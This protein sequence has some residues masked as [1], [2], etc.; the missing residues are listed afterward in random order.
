MPAPDQSPQP[1]ILKSIAFTFSLSMTDFFC[2]LN[3][4]TTSS[5]ANASLK[6]SLS[7]DLASNLISS[8][9]GCILTT[10]GACSSPSL[11]LRTS[12]TS[13][14]PSP[15]TSSSSSLSLSFSDTTISSFC[16]KAFG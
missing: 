4:S 6:L 2:A 13:A 9:S 15:F 3:S 10:C 7:R 14:S 1:G 16:L 12:V 8:I 5:S 11:C